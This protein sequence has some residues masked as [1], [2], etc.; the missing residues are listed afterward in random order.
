MANR[1][2]DILLAVF[3]LIFFVFSGYAFIY[4]QNGFNGNYVETKTV[5]LNDSKTY[6][7]TIR[8]ELTEIQSDNVSVTVT[9][10]NDYD[11][12]GITDMSQMQ[13][14][15]IHL[16]GETVNVTALSI[17]DTTSDIQLSFSQT[18]GMS[19]QSKFIFTNIS[20][21]VMVVVFGVIFILI[22]MV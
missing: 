11:S 8:V 15:S 21:V 13:T 10:I 22:T 17:G 5:V 4:L 2:I 6:D 18:Y 20:V 7:N 19:D 14:E 9:D 12:V 16:N 3:I 1:E